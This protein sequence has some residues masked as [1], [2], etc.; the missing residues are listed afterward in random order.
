[1]LGLTPL[2]LC[3]MPGTQGFAV[4]PR[5]RVA[6]GT[7]GRWRC[8]SK[9]HGRLPEV[10]GATVTLAMIRF[11]VHRTAYPNRERLPAR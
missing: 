3:R 11:T 4:L 8:L 10:S 9:G 7:F 6:A 1:M 5:P 2:I